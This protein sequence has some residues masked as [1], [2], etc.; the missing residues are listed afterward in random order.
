MYTFHVS[1]GD[2]RGKFAVPVGCTELQLDPSGL[3]MAIKTK[4]S[5][6]LLYEVGTGRQV[7]EFV[8]NFSEVGVF[9]FD[10]ETTCMIICDN[11]RKCVKFYELDHQISE[12]S[13]NVIEKMRA[14]PK[15]WDDYPIVLKSDQMLSDRE[16]REYNLKR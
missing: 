12:R 4:L 14:D 2:V 9:S 8:P 10:A 5:T 6:V 11:S 1:D 13:Q 7:F 15:F 16:K 3:Y